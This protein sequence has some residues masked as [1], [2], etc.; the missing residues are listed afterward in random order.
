MATQP[1]FDP[2]QDMSDVSPSDVAEAK[3]RTKN[4][5]YFNKLIQTLPNN[6]PASNTVPK[7]KVLPNMNPGSGS[8]PQIQNYAKGGSAQSYTDKDG[9]INLGSGRISTHVP[10]KSNCDW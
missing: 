8:P 5:D 1:T 9:K 10:S 6:K 3:K 7:P 2:D 4:T